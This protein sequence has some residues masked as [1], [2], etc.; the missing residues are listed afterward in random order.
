MLVY[1]LIL[2][3]APP[4]LSSLY[5]TLFQNDTLFCSVL[6]FKIPYSKNFVLGGIYQYYL[7]HI[8]K[9]ILNC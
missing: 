9:Q 3:E 8:L 2:P 5:P 7:I 1:T 6:L 4:P